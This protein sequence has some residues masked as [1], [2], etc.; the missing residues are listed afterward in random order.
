MVRLNLPGFGKL[1]F[2]NDL[3]DGDAMFLL[4]VFKKKEWYWILK[5]SDEDKVAYMKGPM[6]N[7]PSKEDIEKGFMSKDELLKLLEETIRWGW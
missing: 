6:K 2:K 4:L 1:K 7:K 3:A 5:E